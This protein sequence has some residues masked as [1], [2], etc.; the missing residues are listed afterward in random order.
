MEWGHA[1]RQ[2][3]DLALG[4]LVLNTSGTKLLDG[5]V[6]DNV[7]TTIWSGGS[8]YLNRSAVFTNRGGA[9]F[10]G[11]FD[12]SVSY[13]VSPVGVFNNQGSLVKS[14]GSG[15]TSFDAALNNSGSVTVN[16]G[17]LKLSG[18]GG[19]KRSPPPAGAAPA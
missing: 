1:E 7:G 4:G 19:N 5:R 6:L 13:N 8:L 3:H 16:S 12:G 10:G 11:R 2:W 14:A 9:T 15:A 17:T 18:G